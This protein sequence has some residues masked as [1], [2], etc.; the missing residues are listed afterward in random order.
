MLHQY[1]ADQSG[2]RR[3][4]WMPISVAAVACALVFGAP[5]A[6]ANVIYEY[7]GQLFNTF[8]GDSN[9]YT[10]NDYVHGTFT[11]ASALAPNLVE[12]DISG[13]ILSFVFN[14]FADNHAP[15]T[16]V[17]PG[18][19]YL[20]PMVSTDAAGDISFWRLGF[21]DGLLT[22]FISSFS[23]DGL[24]ADFN[25]D[26][27]NASAQNGAAAWTLGTPGTWTSSAS[28]VPEP[29][30]LILLCTGIVVVGASLRRS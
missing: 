1:R 3:A 15:I 22:H 11:V 9:P 30:G 20:T 17:F 14:D 29:S 10:A 2:F 24:S 26:A 4:F 27:G 13:Q 18:G 16:S 21:S 19:F 23:I 6:R 7:T 25:L 5:T 28:A 12:A 8:V